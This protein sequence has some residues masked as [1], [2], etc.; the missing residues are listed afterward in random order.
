MFPGL[1]WVVSFQHLATADD[2]AD[3]QNDDDDEENAE[4]QTDDPEI[5]SSFSHWNSYQQKV[6]CKRW[7]K[8]THVCSM[9]S[10]VFAFM[11]Q[12]YQR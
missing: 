4:D 3:D 2:A 5:K 1:T 10:T 8:I 11:I 7:K 6:F 9:E 12:Y